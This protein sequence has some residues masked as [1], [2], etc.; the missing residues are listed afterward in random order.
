MVVGVVGACGA[1]WRFRGLV[2]SGRVVWG[3]REDDLVCGRLN[4]RGG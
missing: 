4:L 2:G 1:E 3:L